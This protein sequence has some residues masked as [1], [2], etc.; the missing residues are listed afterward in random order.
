LYGVE[1]WT[2]REVDQIYLERCWRRMGKITWTDHVRN[3]KVFQRVMEERNILQTAKRR[4][5]NW[6]G[7]I[8]CRNYLLKHVTE[9]KIEGK[10][11]VT[12]RRRRRRKQLP[13]YFKE[14]RKML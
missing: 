12:G 3:E 1:T 14:K 4:K 5:A 13:E 8:L 11:E 7:H 2:L 10:K 9:G 6:I